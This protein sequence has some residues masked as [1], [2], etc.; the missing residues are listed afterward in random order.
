[1]VLIDNNIDNTKYQ[2]GSDILT[3]FKKEFG[4][5]LVS[6]IIFIA[7]FLWKDLI[8]DVEEKYFPK[9]YGLTGRAVFVLIVTIGLIAIAIFIRNWF[10]LN[11]QSSDDRGIEFDDQPIGDGDGDIGIDISNASSD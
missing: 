4:L 10:G 3:S 6:A 1:M 11:K 8:S 9:E 5:I 2:F 7:S